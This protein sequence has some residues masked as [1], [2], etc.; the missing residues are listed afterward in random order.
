MARLPNIPPATGSSPPSGE[1]NMSA[2]AA[3]AKAFSSSGSGKGSRGIRGTE[4]PSL[5]RSAAI[6]RRLNGNP[7][8]G[9]EL[10]GL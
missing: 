9:K 7:S 1:P 2:L 5:A 6:S 3:F 4:S 10:K 8:S